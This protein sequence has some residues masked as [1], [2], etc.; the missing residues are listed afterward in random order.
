MITRKQLLRISRQSSI[1]T[2]QKVDKN[3]DSLV[4]MELQ[5]K[6]FSCFCTV[7]VFQMKETE[8]SVEGQTLE[9]KR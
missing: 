5:K 6:I 3:M 9:V 4:S 8:T 7:G 1:N 2:I